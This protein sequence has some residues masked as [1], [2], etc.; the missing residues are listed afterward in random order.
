MKSKKLITAGRLVLEVIY[1][2]GSRADGPD[3]RAA[4]RRMSSEAQQR[5][6]RKYSYQKLELLAAANFGGGDLYATLTYDDRRLPA[7]RAK[8]IA[9]LKEFRRRLRQ[10]R[11]KDGR[12]LR[13]IWASESRHGE[14]RWHHHCLINA[15]SRRDIDE[16]R[17]LWT[18]GGVDVRK[19][20]IDKD[21]SY[22]AIAHYLSKEPRERHGLRVWSCTRSCRRPTVEVFAVDDDEQLQP[23]KG[24]HVYE[25]A[26]SANEFGSWRYAKYLLPDDA[27]KKRRRTA[28][29][30]KR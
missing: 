3:L 11:A 12:P 4:K 14:G 29:K 25:S 7:T 23:P 8:A 2:R 16:I 6:N 13:M 30:T 1:P 24:A 21:H 26:A 22:A 15:S 5:L 27:P 10:A 9:D 28:S 19:I 17:A 20:R 18:A